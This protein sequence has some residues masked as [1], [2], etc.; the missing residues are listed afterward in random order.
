VVATAIATCC[1]RFG[2]CRFWEQESVTRLW[3]DYRSGNYG[4]DMGKPAVAPLV[5]N[6]H[7]D[8]DLC[9]QSHSAVGLKEDLGSV[10]SPEPTAI[11][12]P[13]LMA[14]LSFEDPLLWDSPKSVV[15]FLDTDVIQNIQRKQDGYRPGHLATTTDYSDD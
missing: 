15:H 13:H 8:R 3:E 14:P 5:D 4:I 12:T 10:S 1:P 6:L 11:T 2:F 9:G 7:V